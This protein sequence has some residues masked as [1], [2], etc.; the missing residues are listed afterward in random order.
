MEEGGAQVGLKQR[1]AVYTLVQHSA[2]VFRDDPRFEKAVELTSVK[3]TLRNHIVRCGGWVFNSYSEAD[4]A[5]YMVNY[6]IEPMGLFAFA[7]G[8]FKLLKR[9]SEF[10]PVYIPSQV[11]KDNMKART[12]VPKYDVHVEL[13][14]GNALGIM[15][16]VKRALLSA[17]APRSDIDQ[18]VKE[19]MSGDYNHLLQVTSNWVHADVSGMWESIDDDDEEEN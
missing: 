7:Q 17:N 1:E 13:S 14:D 15:V 9:V 11:D 4:E 10:S 5:E 19:A 18:Y 3:P 2:Y 8:E 6:P 12:A 16:A